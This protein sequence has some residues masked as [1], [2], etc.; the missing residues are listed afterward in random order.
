MRIMNV[1][2][3]FI[4]TNLIKIS[5]KLINIHKIAFNFKMGFARNVLLQLF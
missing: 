3:L 1:H 2:I 5:H 4:L